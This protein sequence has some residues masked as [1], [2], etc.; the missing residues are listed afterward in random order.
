MLPL[1]LPTAV[2]AFIDRYLDF[3]LVVQFDAAPV[4]PAAGVEVVIEAVDDEAVEAVF[5]RCCCAF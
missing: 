3:N 1:V 4:V 5:K 2:S